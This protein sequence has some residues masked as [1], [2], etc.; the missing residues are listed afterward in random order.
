MARIK[1]T[2]IVMEDYSHENAKR[3]NQGIS[4]K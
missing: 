4:E 2:I 3:I 1:I